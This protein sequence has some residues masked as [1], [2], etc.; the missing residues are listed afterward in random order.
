[1]N[2]LQIMRGCFVARREGFFERYVDVVYR[3]MW[4]EPEK[5]DEPEVIRA[6]LERSGLDADAVL[7]GIRQPEIKD[8]LRASTEAAVERGVFGAPSFF[9]DGA[10]YFGKDRLRDVEEEIERLGALRRP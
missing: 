2:T 8:A 7:A 9:V 6:V 1:M 10:L 3:H 5:L 4:S